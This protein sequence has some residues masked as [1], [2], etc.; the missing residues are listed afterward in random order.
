MSTVATAIY[1]KGVLRLLTPLALPEHTRVQVHVETVMD[2]P[3]ESAGPILQRLLALS[4]SL[5]VSDLAE[6]HDHYLYGVD[7]Q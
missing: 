6:Q 2:E 7:R 3:A 1:E 5:G 4:T